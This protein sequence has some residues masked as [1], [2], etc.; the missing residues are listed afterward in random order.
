MNNWEYVAGAGYDWPVYIV[1][2]SLSF[3]VVVPGLHAACGLFIRKEPALFNRPKGSK[4]WYTWEMVSGVILQAMVFLL[5]DIFFPCVWVAPFLIL[6]GVVGYQGGRS[7]A[8]D[9]LRGRWQLAAAIAAGGLLCGFLWEFWNF[10]A[11]P[12]WVYDIPWFDFLHL[13]EMPLLGYGGYIPFAWCFYQLVHLKM[14]RRYLSQSF[15]QNSVF[16]NS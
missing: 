12:K 15:C 14:L 5:P 7:L 3:S 8:R 11:T 6:D 16:G 1:L 13:F 2:S 4:A 9:I 10:W